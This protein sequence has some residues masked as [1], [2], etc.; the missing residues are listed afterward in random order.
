MRPVASKLPSQGHRQMNKRSSSTPAERMKGSQVSLSVFSLSGQHAH[1]SLGQ[2][3]WRQTLK[4]NLDLNRLK[5]RWS[6]L[7]DFT[8]RELRHERGDHLTLSSAALAK[9]PASLYGSCFLFFCNKTHKINI[10][11][12]YALWQGQTSQS[13]VAVFQRTAYSVYSDGIFY[14]DVQRLQ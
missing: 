8:R 13:K 9:L 11:G 10:D 7:R 4:S 14:G 12:D 1:S 5:V 2:T 6:V 3:A